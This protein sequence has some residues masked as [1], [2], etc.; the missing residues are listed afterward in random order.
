[1]LRIVHVREDGSPVFWPAR[2]QQPPAA[3][4][5]GADEEFADVLKPR[6]EA[7]APPWFAS[8]AAF[9]SAHSLQLCSP[10]RKIMHGEVFLARE[11]LA[12][13]PREFCIKQQAIQSPDVCYDSTPGPCAT[14]LRCLLQLRRLMQLRSLAPVFC[15]L[16][17]HVACTAGPGVVRL[18]TTL[19]AYSCD[20]GDWLRPGACATRPRVD[21]PVFGGWH[22][23]DW[24]YTAHAGASLAA[25]SHPEDLAFFDGLLRCVSLQVLLGLHQ[26]QRHMCFSHNDLHLGNVML[27]TSAASSQRLIVACEVGAFLIPKRMPGARLIDFQHSCF[28]LHRDGRLVG[29]TTSNSSGATGFKYDVHNGFALAFDVWRFFHALAVHVWPHHRAVSPELL[30]FLLLAC[31][32]KEAPANLPEEVIWAPHMLCGQTPAD[33]LAHA[34]FD[35]FRAPVGQPADSIYYETPPTEADLE[36]YFRMRVVFALDR[37]PLERPLALSCFDTPTVPDAPW[38]RMLT[39]FADNYAGTMLGRAGLQHKHSPRARA[40]YL[41]ME[42]SLLSVT[43]AHLASDTCREEV[44]RRCADANPQF[45]MCALADAVSVVVHVDWLWIARPVKNE[46]YNARVR[47]DVVL[48]CVLSARAAPPARPLVTAQEEGALL[49]CTQ[50]SELEVFRLYFMRTVTGATQKT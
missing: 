10:P 47:R 15:R 43:M 9:C 49:G 36:R 40:R 11:A 21:L 19:D 3:A 41:W 6:P 14:E 34:V 35:R 27:D 5:P 23:N 16:Y 33:L 32:S 37:L 4:C 30:A 13:H 39:T 46:A 8:P 29:R 24:V 26:A 12:L 25:S 38:R 1:M 44:Q 20:L 28:D 22:T 31:G 17:S 42:L 18:S 45:L 48:P 7:I 50:A 2:E